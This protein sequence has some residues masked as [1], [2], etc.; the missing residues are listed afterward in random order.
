MAPKKIKKK[1]KSPAKPSED[2]KIPSKDK[3]TSSKGFA[4]PAAKKKSKYLIDDI[5]AQGKQ[6]ARKETAK[7]ISEKPCPK[8]HRL[9]PTKTPQ[10]GFYCD[11]CEKKDLAK[12][13]WMYGCRKCDWD[14][15]RQCLNS[16]DH[17]QAALDAK[18]AEEAE[19]SK[20]SKEGCRENIWIDD[21]LGGVYDKEGF[22]GRKTGDGMRIFKALHSKN[23]NGGGTPL[24]PFNCDCCY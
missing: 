11:V 5:F 13:T 17:N 10:A 9:N 2:K 22:T 3:A 15:C 14:V 21:G 8:G 1:R 20:G 19:S 16:Y 24:C 18:A 23:K 7:L 6:D 12:G 4:E